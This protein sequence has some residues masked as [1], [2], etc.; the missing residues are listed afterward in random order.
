MLDAP[1]EVEVEVGELL[2]EAPGEN[3]VVGVPETEEDTLCVVERLSLLDA[4]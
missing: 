3:V 2:A 4:V 1:E